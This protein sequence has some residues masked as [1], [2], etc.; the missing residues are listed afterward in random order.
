[1]CLPIIFSLPPYYLLS[2]LLLCV[3]RSA[4]KFVKSMGSKE[5]FSKIMGIVGPCPPL[6]L[7]GFF[8]F[9]AKEFPWEPVISLIEIDIRDRKTVSSYATQPYFSKS[10]P[11]LHFGCPQPLLLSQKKLFGSFLGWNNFFPSHFLACGISHYHT[12]KRSSA[13]L[14]RLVSCSLGYF[15]SDCS[16]GLP[17]DGEDHRFRAE[18]DFAG[19]LVI[20]ISPKRNRPRGKWLA[21]A[22][23]EVAK[24]RFSLGSRSSKFSFIV[25]LR[26][27]KVCCFLPNCFSL[28]MTT[29]FCPWLSSQCYYAS[30]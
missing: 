3:G 5:D 9:L 11:C 21:L 26:E 20:L 6:K 8:F 16:D 10:P 2:N 25:T 18:R 15:E 1:M 22:Y 30:P 24:M 14:S 13:T 23:R 7:A 17:M 29:W 19:H 27:E 28:V 4:P 12:K